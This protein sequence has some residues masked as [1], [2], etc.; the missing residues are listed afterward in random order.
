VLN[1]KL[2]YT[3]VDPILLMHQGK[4]WRLNAGDDIELEQHPSLPNFEEVKLLSSPKSKGE[5]N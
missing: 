3:G 4:V 1:L 2:K 5:D